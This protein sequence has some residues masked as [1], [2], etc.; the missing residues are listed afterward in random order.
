MKTNVKLTLALLAGVAIGAVTVGGLN[1][2][3][4][5]PGAYAVVDISE[6]TDPEVFKQVG[7]KAAPAATSAGGRFI[8]RTDNVI[9]LHGAAPKRFVIIAFESID[10]AK[11]FDASAAQKEVTALADKSTK[12]RRFIVEGM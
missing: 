5:A 10:K 3:S 4:K 12:S 6:I 11:A 2:Q 7:P 1:A 8:A 9:A